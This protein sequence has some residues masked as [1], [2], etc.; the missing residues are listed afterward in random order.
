MRALVPVGVYVLSVPVGVRSRCSACPS[1]SSRRGRRV[2]SARWTSARVDLRE[3]RGRYL[4]PHQEGRRAHRRS[5]LPLQGRTSA[6]ESQMATVEQQV[7]ETQNGAR[8]RATGEIPVENPATGE[9]IATV[10]DLERRAGRRDGR[11]R[12]RR[13][14][15]V[16]GLRLR[17]P[18]ARDAARPEVADGQRRADRSRRS[19]RRP[20]RPSRTPSSPRSATPATPSASGP[21]T[22]PSTSPTSRSSPASCSSRARS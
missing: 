6:G 12:P 21:S 15:R 20:A 13:A 10:P 5:N 11:A 1:G 19:S 8:R 3:T 17:G 16:G 14:A 22:A 4:S 18:R 2:G 9:T 7:P